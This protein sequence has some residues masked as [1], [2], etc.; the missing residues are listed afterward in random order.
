[1]SNYVTK[2]CPECFTY[3]KLEATRCDSCKTKVGP[4]NKYGV[5]KRVVNWKAYLICLI[6]WILL[7]LYIWKVFL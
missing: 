1:M 6:V 4:I 2:K 5:A 3:L 7:G